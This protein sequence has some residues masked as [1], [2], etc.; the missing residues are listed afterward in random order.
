MNARSLACAIAITM[1]V[2]AG[3]NAADPALYEAA[4]K[5]A[6]VVWYTT[7]IVNQ[8]VRPRPSDLWPMRTSRS[9]TNEICAWRSGG[10]ARANPPRILLD[11][12]VLLAALVP[13]Q[14][15]TR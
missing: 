3:T 1:A 10:S 11:D 13:W 5:E 6:G 9:G 2:P 15:Q 7:L 4:K 12:R 8:A 14:L